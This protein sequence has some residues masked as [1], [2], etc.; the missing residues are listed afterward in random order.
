MRMGRDTQQDSPDLYHLCP[1]GFCVVTRAGLTSN[2]N[3]SN[4]MSRTPKPQEVS[5]KIHPALIF[6]LKRSPL[7]GM[8]C[9]G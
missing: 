8:I 3:N 1:C 2:T 9:S 5:S 6:T 7:L 4:L